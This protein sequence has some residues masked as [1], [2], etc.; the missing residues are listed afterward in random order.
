MD[1]FFP[2]F[3]ERFDMKDPCVCCGESTAPGS[4]K[5]VNRTP[6]DYERE[7]GILYVG[8]WCADC[9]SWDCA[10]CGEDIEL[11]GDFMVDAGADT[12]ERVCLDCLRESDTLDGEEVTA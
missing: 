1:S 7:D 5:F 2:L 12:Y 11:D 3:F 9:L 6:G 8:Y 4:G 10:R